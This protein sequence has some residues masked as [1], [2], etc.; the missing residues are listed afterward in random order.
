MTDPL[1]N[2]VHWSYDQAGQLVSTTDRNGLRRDF[3]YN[4]WASRSPRPLVCRR[5]RHRGV[6]P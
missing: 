1:G 5:W 6:A 2:T 3:T 4:G